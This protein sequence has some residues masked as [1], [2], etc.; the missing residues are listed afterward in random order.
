MEKNIITLKTDIQ[1]LY[2]DYITVKV[3]EY[4]EKEKTGRLVI[5]FQKGNI[6]SIQDQLIIAGV[7]V[8]N[9]E[10]SKSKSVETLTEDRITTIIK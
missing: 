3:A 9:Y 7:T 4:V 10:I 1:K 6:N 2:W 8:T 5:D